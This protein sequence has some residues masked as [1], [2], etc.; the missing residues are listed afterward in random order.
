MQGRE[1]Y[2][3]GIG[4]Q[5]NRLSMDVNRVIITVIQHVKELRSAVSIGL[6]RQYL[7]R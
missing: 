4:E 1:D 2:G 5:I 3:H 7:Q 6:V